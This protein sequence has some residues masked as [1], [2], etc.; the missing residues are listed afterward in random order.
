MKH[1]KFYLSALLIGAFLL[2]AL[3]VFFWPNKEKERVTRD[4][5]NILKSD[6]LY[7][8][9]ELDPIGYYVS[10]DTVTGFNYEVMRHLEKMSGIRFKV[11]VENSLNESFNHLD[12][13]KYD[14]IA[15]NIPI[16]VKLKEDYSFTE[17]IVLNKLILVQRKAE[18]ND[19]IQPIRSHL[20]LAKKTIH[21]PKNAPEKL[22]IENLSHEIG[23]TIYIQE[24]GRAHV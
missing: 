2:I 11:F 16:N 17:P 24:I 7:I 3:A 18:Y 12:E 21:I 10:G 8:V 4:W 22:R 1:T 23:D 6:T 15:R 5:N 13:G 19:S 20:E 14:L 9:T